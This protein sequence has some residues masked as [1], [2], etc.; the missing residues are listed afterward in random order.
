[1]ERTD[2]TCLVDAV[3]LYF[4]PRGYQPHEGSSAGCFVLRRR[5]EELQGGAVREATVTLQQLAEHAHNPLLVKT[6]VSTD[7][8]GLG[9]PLSP[10]LA[11]SGTGLRGSIAGVMKPGTLCADIRPVS[12][13]DCYVSLQVV[14]EDT[15]TRY[16]CA[17]C[18]CVP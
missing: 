13:L 18:V 15:G 5:C 7:T 8:S 2:S 4:D 6:L 3:G 17:I 12:G 11:F 16:T 14:W 10:Q 9:S 1:M